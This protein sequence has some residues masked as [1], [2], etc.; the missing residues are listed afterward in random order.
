MTL[1]QARDMVRP[2]LYQALGTYPWNYMIDRSD[3]WADHVNDFLVMETHWKDRHTLT[4]KIR[5]DM[6][7]DIRNLGLMFEFAL[8]FVLPGL[9]AEEE[10]A[11]DYDAPVLRWRSQ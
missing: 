7:T 1:E 9:D 3:V 10:A 2:A 4:R 6:L 8:Q 5:A 11:V